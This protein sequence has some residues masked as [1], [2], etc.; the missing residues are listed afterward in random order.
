MNNYDHYALYKRPGHRTV[1]IAMLKAHRLRMKNI[2]RAANGL[3]P[4]QTYSEI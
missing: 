2:R 3:T 4:K 1:T